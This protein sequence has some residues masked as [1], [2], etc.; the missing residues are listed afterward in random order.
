MESAF[1]KVMVHYGSSWVARM[2]SQWKEIVLIESIVKL[3]VGI[4]M[5]GTVF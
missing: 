3:F 4:I 5:I 1:L 2:V